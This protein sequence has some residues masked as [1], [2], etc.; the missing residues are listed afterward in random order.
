MYVC[1][2]NAVTDSEIREA[3]E[4]GAVHVDH[5]AARCGLGTGCGRCQEVAQQLIDEHL[6]ADL[7][8]AIA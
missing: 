2:C 7:S 6:A 1:L 8:Y 5:L 4:E 3:V